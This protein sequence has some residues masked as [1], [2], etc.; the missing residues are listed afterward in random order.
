MLH[1]TYLRH[2]YS[3][4]YRPDTPLL[5]QTSN[6]TTRTA[7]VGNTS[8]QTCFA[9]ALEPRERRRRRPR[10]MEERRPRGETEAATRAPSRPTTY[11]MTRSWDAG[12][13]FAVPRLELLI[14]AASPERQTR[15]S[16]GT[17]LSRMI[18]SPK[19]RLFGTR[20]GI[21]LPNL[22]ERVSPACVMKSNLV[23]LLSP[24]PKETNV[25]IGLENLVPPRS[26][27]TLRYIILYV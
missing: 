15:A 2:F 1:T 11:Q 12:C 5:Q 6:V 8:T 17:L 19:P 13:G 25:L 18:R 16:P 14:V 22:L 4:V 24:I 26:F 9:R 7:E 20:A 23:A 27:D 10:R 3:I 21:Q